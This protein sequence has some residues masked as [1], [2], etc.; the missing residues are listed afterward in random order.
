QAALSAV[1]A[2]QQQGSHLGH[3]RR[4]EARL[5]HPER[6]DGAATT[7]LCTQGP[8]VG[9]RH[10]PMRKLLL[11]ITLASGL[12]AQTSNY[13]GALDTNSTLFVTADNVQ[14]VLTVAMV[15]SDT[16]AVVQSST[17]FQ[18]NMIAT[19]CDTVTTVTT[20]VSKCSAWE[21]MLVT[22]VA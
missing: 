22:N 12:C 14:T 4:D 20:G 19:V 8:A 2:A 11:V 17:G 1:P 6:H 10:T 18:A 15:P 21:H 16:V 3:G 7:A 9:Q 5:D 13:P